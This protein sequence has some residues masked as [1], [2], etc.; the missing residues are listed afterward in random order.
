MALLLRSA[1]WLIRR[2]PGDVESQKLLEEIDLALAEEGEAG[3]EREEAG[4]ASAGVPVDA[5]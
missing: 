2:L 3:G 5:A 1:K 4:E